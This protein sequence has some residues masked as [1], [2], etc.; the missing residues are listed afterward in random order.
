MSDRDEFSD[1]FAYDDFSHRDEFE[2]SNEF[3]EDD[4]YS[5][6]PGS[7]GEPP[8][9]GIGGRMRAATKRI[10]GR[11]KKVGGTGVGLSDFDE[12]EGDATRVSSRGWLVGGAAVV[13]IGLALF[14]FG[15]SMGWTVANRQEP[16]YSGPEVI[17]VPMP[18]Y[19]SDSQTTMPDVRGLMQV[20]AQ[21]ALADAG[22]PA[23]VVT[24]STKPAAGEP[25]IVVEQVPAFGAEN[26][27]AVQLLV[28]SPAVVPEVVGR[29]E[30]EATNDLVALGTRVD[31]FLRFVPGTAPGA[32]VEVQP[33]VGSPLGDSVMLVVAE[34]AS[35]AF[36]SDLQRLS[37]NCSSSASAVDGEGYPNSLVCAAGTKPQLTE[38]LVDR[39]AIE[40][41]GTLG[42]PDSGSADSA[43]RIRIVVDGNEV[44]TAS[45]SYGQPFEFRVPVANALRL[46]IEVQA[47]NMPER[48]STSWSAVLADARLEGSSADIAELQSR[49]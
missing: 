23:A 13:L 25:G 38:W 49:S 33:A 27:A 48:T 47:V 29:P 6:S 41:V 15:F 37:G 3:S 44:G 39:A 19:D 42:V 14:G 35:S 46:G 11:R 32:V 17:E 9:R 1:D 16:T 8:G 28:S 40:L 10:S 5:D 24:A 20:E 26:P 43:V 45:A 18:V 22:I 31:R 2:I 34:A 21:T 12:S 30:R 4:E 36:L 7:V